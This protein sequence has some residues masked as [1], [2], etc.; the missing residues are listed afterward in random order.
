VQSFIIF[1]RGTRCA[2]DQLSSMTTI[3]PETQKLV[4]QDPRVQEAIKNAAKKAGNDAVD[5]M[6][7]PEVQ[8]AII[9]TVKEKAPKYASMAKE[10]VTKFVSDPRVQA[11]AYKA[12]GVVFGAAGQSLDRF[13]GVIEQGPAGV[14]LLAFA[15]G[16]LS[17]VNAVMYCFQFTNI[18]NHLVLYVISIYQIIFAITTMIFEAPS[19]VVEKIPG[20]ITYRDVLMQKAEGLAEVAGR[21]L[22]YI[23]QGTL[24]LGLGT[25][26]ELLDVITGAYVSFIGILHIIMHF[27]KLQSFTMS[28]RQGYEKVAP[29]A[30]GP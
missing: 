4:L 20:I 9:A 10:E 8:A 28:V 19:S 25:S 17:C 13:I 27:G 15:G 6:K 18:A 14:R 11:Q 23:F 3:D 30:A 26:F 7:D 1:S 12:A 22:F 5:S 24:W 29:G 16:I 21:G 2:L